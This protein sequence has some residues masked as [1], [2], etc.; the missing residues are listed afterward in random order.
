M[1]RQLALVLLALPALA[2]SGVPRD[3][4]FPIE[5]LPAEFRP[6]AEELLLQAMDREALFTIVGGLKPVSSGW[7]STRIEVTKP[8]IESL[9]RDRRILETFHSGGEL[10]A[11]LQP[12]WRVYEETRYLDG[13]FVHRPSLRETIRRHRDYFGFYGLTES[14]HP[15]QTIMAVEYDPSP[16][17]ERGYGYLFGYPDYAVDFFVRSGFEQRRTG[18]LVPRD[19]ISIPVFERET[20]RFVYAV[21][22]GH[23]MNDEDRRLRER[24][25]P[26][27]AMYREL[28]PKYIGEGKPGIVQLIRDWFDDGSGR[29]SSAT[30]LRKA[31]A[32]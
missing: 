8:D 29:C 30:A 5:R 3:Q 1:I 4:C 32:R 17:R 27:L 22:K 9:E 10:V 28:R 23:E 18:Q 31:L 15:I 16:Q 11:T 6:R 19:F 12:F 14:S 2:V 21:P 25:A 20:N 7:L 13:Y 24:A 26:I